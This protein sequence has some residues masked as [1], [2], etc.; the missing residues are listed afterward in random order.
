MRVV[1]AAR[2]KI[3][4]PCC[5]KR[6]EAAVSFARRSR[7]RIGEHVHFAGKPRERRHHCAAH[8]V[9]HNELRNENRIGDVRE[10]VVETLQR[11]KSAEPV[12]ISFRVG[13]DKHLS[14][15]RH[16]KTR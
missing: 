10:R 15:A 11:V 4:L 5:M 6:D 3:A 12:E 14:D 16:Q 8:I 2:E 13:A 1:Q 7:G 9:F